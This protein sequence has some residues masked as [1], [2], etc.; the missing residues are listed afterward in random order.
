MRCS[1]VRYPECTFYTSVLFL[2]F[3]HHLFWQKGKRWDNMSDSV[4]FGIS[5]KIKIIA[6]VVVA[7][8]YIH[9]EANYWSD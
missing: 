7:T 1:G 4:L 8:S 6:H 5:A 2:Y 9:S 3:I